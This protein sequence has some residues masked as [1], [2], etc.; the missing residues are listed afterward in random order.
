MDRIK[1]KLKLLAV[2]P[3]GD[4]E[5]LGFL[6]SKDTTPFKKAT[7]LGDVLSTVIGVLTVVA[8]LWFIIQFFIGAFSL[9]TAGGDKTATENAQKRLTNSVIGL[10]IVIAAIFLIDLIGNILGIDILDPVTF[11]ISL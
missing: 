4:I 6:G 11:L 8:G 5:G 2:T 10:V 3:L 9:I 1:K 7:M